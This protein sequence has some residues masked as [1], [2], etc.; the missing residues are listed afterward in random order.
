M[1][2]WGWVGG[3]YRDL[4]LKDLDP[5]SCLSCIASCTE[6]VFHIRHLVGYITQETISE[7]NHNKPP[8]PNV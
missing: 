2:S 1:G 3:C 7:K 8:M 4:Y 6:I 5:G